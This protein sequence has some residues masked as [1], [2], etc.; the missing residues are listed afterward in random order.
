MPR[1]NMKL[2]FKA[3]F[4]IKSW[5]WTKISAMH[6]PTYRDPCVSGW[7]SGIATIMFFDLAICCFIKME[8]KRLVLK[9]TLYNFVDTWRNT[10]TFRAW[11]IIAF[12][13]YCSLVS[14]TFEF[15][16]FMKKLWPM[17]VKVPWEFTLFSF[18]NCLSTFSCLWITPTPDFIF[19]DKVQAIQLAK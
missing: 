12:H 10:T 5:K 2:G 1:A 13:T 15:T 17:E 11:S 14:V 16:L 6:F 19:V 18:F 7:I 3:A 8:C 9:I 4:F